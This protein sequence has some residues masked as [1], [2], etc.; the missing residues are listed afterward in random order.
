MK[1]QN[2][3]FSNK[4]RCPPA[5]LFCQINFLAA[6]IKLKKPS[7]VLTTSRRLVSFFRIDHLQRRGLISPSLW[8][9]FVIFD[10]V[11]SVQPHRPRA[12]DLHLPC[13]LKL[14][15]ISRWRS[16]CTPRQRNCRPQLDGMPACVGTQRLQVSRRTWQGIPKRKVAWATLQRQSQTTIE[17][18]RWATFKSRVQ[19]QVWV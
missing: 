6:G 14:E 11:V 7:Y 8:F 17:R 2:C 1:M 18:R 4:G 19:N 13:L 16:T 9:L 15:K 10:C 12:V 3:V 5:S